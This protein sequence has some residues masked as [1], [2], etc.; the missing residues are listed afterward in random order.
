MSALLP[1]RAVDAHDRRAVRRAAEEDGALCL[2][3]LLPLDLVEALAVDVDGWVQELGWVDAAGGPQVP[4][5][6][7]DAPDFV[8]L[9]QWA[10]VADTFDALRRHADLLRVL[11]WLVGG[12]VTAG[13]GDLVRVGC[14][15]DP[16][17]GTPPHQDAFYV[18]GEPVLWTAWTPLLPMPVDLG[19]VAV[20][21]GS[22]RLGTLDHQ[23]EGVG[24]QGVEVPADVRWTGSDLAPGDVVLFEGRTVH[25]TL[26][27]AMPGVLRRSADFRYVP[28][29]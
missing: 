27:H 25:R 21:A 12:P 16:P 5:P 23:G 24:T 14:A 11:G 15:G 17:R 9:Q 6:A 18:Q 1:W 4:T 22:H 19:P 13:R 28:R 10:F 20:W 29:R 3:G 26:P 7:Y 8:R 2:R